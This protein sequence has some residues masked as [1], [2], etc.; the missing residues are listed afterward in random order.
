MRTLLEVAHVITRF[1]KSFIEKYS[2]C[3]QVI[4]VFSHLEQCRTSALGGHVDVCSECGAIRVSYNSC[5]DRHCPK[6]QGMER[7]L[8]IQ[9]RKEEILPVGYFHVV[10]TLPDDLHSLSLANMKAVYSSLF[11]A[12]WQTMCRFSGKQGVQTGM[13]T[14]LHTW[15]SNLHYH[16][17]LHC[18]VPGGGIGKDGKWKN[19]EN[20]YNKKSFLF[21]VNGMSKVFRAKFVKDLTK[22]VKIPKPLR[23]RIFEKEWVVYSKAPFKGTD[24]VVEYLGRYSYRVAISNSR[25]KEITDKDVVFEYKDYKDG[26]RRKLMTLSGVEFLHRFSQHILPSGFVRIRHYG[27][28][29][30]SNREKLRDLQCSMKVTLS[31]KKRN[32]K[33]WTEVCAQKWEEYNLCKCCG[34]AQM[35]TIQTFRPTRPPPVQIRRKW[36][37]HEI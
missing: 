26:G 11:K 7:E 10:F 3:N 31:P 4:R 8:W 14:I 2:P 20:M 18:I 21:T 28:L 23:K 19:Y 36:N 25:I 6:C 13:T 22:S 27:F 30:A 17:H 24:K 1:K 32:K 34:K 35:I 15:G 37:D 33:K 9:A 5:R 12:S 29:A 16:P